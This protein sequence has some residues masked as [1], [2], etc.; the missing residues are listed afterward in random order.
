MRVGIFI[1]LIFVGLLAPLWVLIV[2]G[3]CYAL[4]KKA[5][6]LIPLG[7]FFDAMFGVGVSEF[8]YV[9]TLSFAGI[10][11]LSE[12]VKPRLSFYDS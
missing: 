1:M 5:Y 10:V 6:E 3:A 11:L 8:P 9:Y 7:I 12:L 2:C 4:W